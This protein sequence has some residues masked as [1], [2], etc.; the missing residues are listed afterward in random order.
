MKTRQ[1]TAEIFG[2]TAS[3]PECG[4]TNS[5]YFVWRYI[6]RQADEYVANCYFCGEQFVLIMRGLAV[7]KTVRHNEILKGKQYIPGEE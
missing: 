6:P 3:C 4:H 5:Y 2:A 7:K 1:G